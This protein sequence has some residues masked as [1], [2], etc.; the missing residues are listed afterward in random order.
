M[1]SVI[2]DEMR[3]LIGRPLETVVSFPIDRSDIRRWALAVY[4]PEQPPGQFWDEQSPAA[5]AWGGLVAPLDFNPFAWMVARRSGPGPEVAPL[6]VDRTLVMAGATEHLLGVKPPDLVH[7]LN[8]GIEV[9]YGPARMRPGDMVTDNAAIS[10]Y[11]E[12]QGRLGLMLFTTTD[13]RWTNQR[14]EHVKTQ[15]LT[16]IRY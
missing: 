15:R 2:N 7:G 11:T 12:R 16:Y 6:E 13:H 3:G 1:T 5:A 8:G 9:T 4:Y 10:D 14:G